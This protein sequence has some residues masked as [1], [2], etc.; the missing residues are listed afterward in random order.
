MKATKRII[1]VLLATVMLLTAIPFASA[2]EESS[3]DSYKREMLEMGF[4][5]IST[6]EFGAFLRILQ[7]FRY[8]LTG[9]EP[10]TERIEVTM[11]ETILN[12]T[13]QIC[14]ESGLD[15]AL[16]AANL[17]TSTLLQITLR[18]STA[19]IQRCSV[20]KDMPRRL[21]M[22]L[23]ATTLWLPYAIQSAHL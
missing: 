8:L 20:R 23:R 12:I 4:P 11:D 9:I 10:N 21:N 14:A 5:V 6:E 17:P 16:I 19:L 3:I 7:T 1:A 22:Q 18:T 2:K 13:S 15:F